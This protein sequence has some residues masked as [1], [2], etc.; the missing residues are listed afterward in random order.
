MITPKL[1]SILGLRVQGD[2]GP[3]T[4]YTNRRGRFVFYLHSPPKKPFTRRQL[5]QQAK[6]IIIARLWLTLTPAD[7]RGWSAAADRANLRISGFNLFCFSYLKRDT[8]LARTIQTKT[9]INLHL[10]PGLV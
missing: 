8:T 5:H 2:V 9:K 10:P 1:L 4:T 3:W 7:R 6:L